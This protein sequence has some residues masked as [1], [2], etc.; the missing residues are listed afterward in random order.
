MITGKELETGVTCG[1]LTK[2]DL[3]RWGVAWPPRPGWM[4]ALWGLQTHG[5]PPSNIFEDRTA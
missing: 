2:E 3:A 5:G 1:G 4:K